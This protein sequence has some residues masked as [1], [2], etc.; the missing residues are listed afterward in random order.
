[1]PCASVR[2]ATFFLRPSA[3]RLSIN[4]AQT[5]GKSN[6]LNSRGD[7]EFLADGA[8]VLFDR[9][10]ASGSALGDFLH[11]AIAGNRSQNF[12]LRAGQKFS[13]HDDGIRFFNG[14]AQHNALP[15]LKEALEVVGVSFVACPDDHLEFSYYPFPSS[16]CFNSACP[17]LTLTWDVWE[18]PQGGEKNPLAQL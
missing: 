16:D 9:R 14:F 13:V 7:L 15:A 1:M 12:L 6:G 5:K 8:K 10:F 2:R 3:T 11:A 4:E 17:L 18:V